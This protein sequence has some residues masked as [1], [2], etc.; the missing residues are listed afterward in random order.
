[1]G[2]INAE[3]AKLRLACGFWDEVEEIIIEEVEFSNKRCEFDECPFLALKG[4]AFCT[5]HQKEWKYIKE[6]RQ[7]DEDK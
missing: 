6:G 1:M 2:I 7:P 5:E 4:L 3:N